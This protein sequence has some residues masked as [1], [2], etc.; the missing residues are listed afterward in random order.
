MF[1]RT[2]GAGIERKQGIGLGLAFVDAVAKR[3]SGHVEVES[4]LGKGSSFC[5]IIP[6]VDTVE[7]DSNS[8][9]TAYLTAQS[10][11]VKLELFIQLFST[12]NSLFPLSP[13][14]WIVT[15]CKF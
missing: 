5:L 1:R 14:F 3:H 13:L 11:A 15:N 10:K 6:K 7:W 8:S 12:K 9:L 2:R 4:E